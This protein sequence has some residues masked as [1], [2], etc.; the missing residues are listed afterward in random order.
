MKIGDLVY[1]GFDRT[2]GVVVE[3]R[4]N[5]DCTCLFDGQIYLCAQRSL[6]VIS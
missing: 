3:I 2:V 1:F 6:E 4:E 5:G